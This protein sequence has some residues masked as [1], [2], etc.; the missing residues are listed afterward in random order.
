MVSFLASR[1]SQP[2]AFPFPFVI[3]LC[4]SITFLEPFWPEFPTRMFW[5]NTRVENAGQ[6]APEGMGKTSGIGHTDTLC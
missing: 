3:V 4:V 6:N 5:Q 2:K 1:R